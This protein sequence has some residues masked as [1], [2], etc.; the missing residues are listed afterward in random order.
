MY[1]LI[2]KMRDVPQMRTT[3]LLL[4]KR[5]LPRQFGQYMTCY[6]CVTHAWTNLARVR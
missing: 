3:E 6:L 1:L 4:H 2:N 5:P